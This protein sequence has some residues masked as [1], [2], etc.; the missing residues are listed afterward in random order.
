MLDLLSQI[1]VAGLPEPEAEFA[2]TTLRLWRFDFAWPERKIAVEIEGGTWSG[3]RH[4]RGKGF[5]NDCT[6][7]NSAA[8]LGWTVLRVTT[9]M[10]RDGRALKTIEEALKQENKCRSD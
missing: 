4:V 9:A 5:E 3:G 1:V 2:F 8:I 6:K 10:V 7:Y